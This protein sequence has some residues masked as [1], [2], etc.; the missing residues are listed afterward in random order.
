[1]SVMECQRPVGAR[2]PTPPHHDELVYGQARFVDDVHR[3]GALA[4]VRAL[5]AAGVVVALGHSGAT[6]DQA[7]A[8]ADAGARAITH[9]FNAQRGLGHRE[10]GV[11]GVGLTDARFTCGL[12][13]DTHNVAAE[14]LRLVLAVA[15]GTVPARGPGHPPCRPTGRRGWPTAP[16][17][18]PPSSSGRRCAPWLDSAS[19][20]RPRWR[21]P[22]GSPVARCGTA[23]PRAPDADGRRSPVA[24]YSRPSSG[25][26]DSGTLTTRWGSSLMS[27]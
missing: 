23:R 3:P 4:A 22:P 2:R 21:P 20:S 25:T 24:A 6:G 18:A 17:P 9:L 12:I 10:L 26:I 14:V 11:A 19:T 13:A 16:S 15:P 8:A 27:K 1:M 7:R 5:S